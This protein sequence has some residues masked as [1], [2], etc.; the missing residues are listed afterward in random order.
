[1]DSKVIVAGAIVAL[2]AIGAMAV[3]AL[4]LTSNDRTPQPVPEC[5]VSGYVV[6][7]LGQGLPGLSVT[8]HVMG[9]APEGRE[10]ELYNLTATTSDT[11]AEGRYAFDS[12]AIPEG[13]R[14]AYVE[15]SKKV[16]DTT[17]Y[18]RSNNYTLSASANI[19]ASIVLKLP[20]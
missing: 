20:P 7:T 9:D 17:S 12:V 2:V 8:L 19:S 13:A 14:Y 1:M 16:G 5:K 15:T 18:G 6:S 3:V 10:K 11:P 4:S